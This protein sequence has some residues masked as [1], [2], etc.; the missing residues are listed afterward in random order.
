MSTGILQEEKRSFSPIGGP[1]RGW[2]AKLFCLGDVCVPP[3]MVSTCMF[4]NKAYIAKM[5]SLSS[6]ICLS[7]E[8]KPSSSCRWNSH[9]LGKQNRA[10]ATLVLGH[11]PNAFLLILLGLSGAWIPLTMVSVLCTWQS[12]VWAVQS[13]TD[14]FPNRSQKVVLGHC[15]SAP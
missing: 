1:Y 12:W 4:I 7:G 9:H 5:P 15:C 10:C 8:I 13:G 14:S 3:W 6:C 2:K 11:G